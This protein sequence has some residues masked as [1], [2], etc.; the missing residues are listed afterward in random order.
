M[1]EQ[2]TAAAVAADDTL[3]TAGI[4]PEIAAAIGMTGATGDRERRAELVLGRPWSIVPEALI[5]ITSRMTRADS[6]AAG[7]APEAAVGR[8][9]AGGR[10]T[11]TGGQIAVLPLRGTITPRGSLFSLL[12]GLGGGL[13]SFRESFREALADGDV[14]AIVLDIDSP[15][16]LIDLV[17]EAAEEIR[18]AR[19]SKPIVAIANTLCASAAYWIASQADEVVITPSGQVGSIGVFLIHEDYSRMEEMLGIKTTIISAGDHKTDGNP[20]EPLSKGARAALQ[21]QVDDLYAMFAGAVAAGRGTSV[22]AVQA[23]FG[24]GRCVLA[25]EALQT[26]MV[27]SIETFEE[28]VARLGGA[29]KDPA[30]TP[31]DI[32]DDIDELAP[33]AGD[34]TPPARAA[35]DG[36]RHPAAD[37]LSEDALREQP[38]SY[39]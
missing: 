33:G 9:A 26:G 23:G 30:A 4:E 8:R 12:F 15:G 34:E 24:R 25:R 32:E 38:A 14:G 5:E 13:Q 7:P 39:L 10:I 21:Q 11:A 19:G 18:A 2:D 27:D 35:E 31:A 6:D 29:A 37:Y 16:G 36:G 20:Y 3:I 17:P 1:E 22:Q 28:V